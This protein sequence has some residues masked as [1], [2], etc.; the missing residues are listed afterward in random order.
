MSNR[1]IYRISKLPDTTDP[2]LQDRAQDGVV[3]AIGADTE[4]LLRTLA[5]LLAASAC[6]ALRFYY[7]P[8]GKGIKQDERLQVFLMGQSYEDSETLPLLLETG[9]FRRFYELEPVDDCPVDWTQLKAAC[10]IIRR[11]TIIPSNVTG[12]LNA[13]T[14]P[15]YYTLTPFAPR[16][17]CD[18][19]R[20]DAALDRQEYPVLI[21]ICVEPVDLARI[22]QQD[23]TYL[24]T[25]QAINRQWDGDDELPVKSWFASQDTAASPSPL[26]QREPLA[27]SVLRTEQHN[28]EALLQPH[29]AFHIRVFAGQAETARVLASTVANSAFADGSYELFT[30]SRND[31][32]F[33]RLCVGG[34]TLRVAPLPISEC[35][36]TDWRDPRFRDLLQLGTVAPPDQLL[37][38]FTPPHASFGTTKCIPSSTDPPTADGEESIV[39][40]HDVSCEHGKASGESL[41]LARGLF[42]RDLPKG[43]FVS[44]VPGNGKTMLIF[45]LM[46]QLFA[47]RIP[48]IVFESGNKRDYRALKCL[49]D[50]G[51]KVLAGLAKELRIWTP[52]CDT[53][54]PMHL[55]PL[56]LPD[57]VATNEWIENIVGCFQGA[58]PMFEP[59]PELLAQSLERVYDS[60]RARKSPA[61]MMDLYQAAKLTLRDTD[62]AGDVKS[63]LRA[64]IETRLGSLTRR[65]AGQILQCRHSMPTIDD[66]MNS[67]SVVELASLT[68]ER[69]SLQTLFDLTCINARIKA[70]A[71]PGSTV[72]RVL[73]V[74]E[75]HNLVGHDHNTS[76]TSEEH[77][78]PKAH[79]ADLVCRMLAEY[80]S[81][82]V[83]IVIVDQ[84]ASAV[85]P[86]VVK[87]TATKIAFRQ[88]DEQERETI[89]AAMSS[90]PMEAQ[91][92]GRLVP[93]LCLFHTEGWYRAKL[94]RTRNL[95]KEF[96]IP[97]SPVGRAILP[98]LQDD[99]W[100]RNA[101]EAR[102]REDLDL[103]EGALKTVDGH[104]AAVFAE[105]KELLGESRRLVQSRG[106]LQLSDFAPIM[107]KARHL[108]ARL[109]RALAS[110]R[111]QCRPWLLDGYT[112]AIANKDLGA[113]CA[114]LLERF[115]STVE[116]GAAECL[117]ILE[118]L[119]DGTHAIYSVLKGGHQ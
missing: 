2:R 114:H 57:G 95:Q 10:D 110:F 66:L 70:T 75:G 119:A 55:N 40:G 24:G 61:T 99:E 41:G 97:P 43:V 49:K 64:A 71:N 20:L 111:S 7:R 59:L 23:L 96:N 106:N 89:T 104:R 36:L 101:T 102:Q 28:Y 13:R 108:R 11:Q 98:Y 35:L 82:G 65:A 83:S 93:G 72:R 113:R 118:S 62:Y 92:I 21:E 19:L 47:R 91:L 67:Y 88:A 117:R 79:A 8:A 86:E 18:Y 6:V 42:L 73:I 107:D 52:G 80:R 34:N 53:V 4:H 74:E 78:D 15:D 39:I 3:A 12:E 14:L 22:V 85:A 68:P 76:G 31:P 60:C 115:R 17:D 51:D 44:G 54:A 38:V 33:E 27:D 63:N 37:S 29:L 56:D 94:I 69:A 46:M 30:T 1:S 25:L 32:W 105:T 103:L 5:A 112:P 16:R 116:P 81:L 84:L 77:V 90:G 87:Q 48:F 58:M 50:C 100:F 9:P 26:R 109:D 45:H